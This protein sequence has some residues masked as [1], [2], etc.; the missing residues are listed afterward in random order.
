MY[1]GIFYLHKKQL[2]D[3][4]NKL[5]MRAVRIVT[6]VKL[7]DRQRNDD[8]L[9]TLGIIPTEKLVKRQFLLEM[10]KWGDQKDN[11][12]PQVYKK[13]RGSTK[14]KIRHAGSNQRTKDSFLYPMQQIWNDYNHLIDHS[15]P[16]KRKRD[17]RKILA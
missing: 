16:R 17:I 9:N 4:I 11:I 15:S 12:F 6:K 8:L 13:T 10:S 3:K 7:K 2:N 5:V 14:N 1:G